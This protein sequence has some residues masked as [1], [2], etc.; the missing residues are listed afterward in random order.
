[1]ADE[2]NKR[3][4]GELLNP[5]SVRTKLI[6]MRLF[7]V[8]HELL[9]DSIIRPPLSFFA[10]DGK[11]GRPVPSNEYKTEVLK[12]DPKGKCDARRGSIEWLKKMSAID[13]S[14]ALSIHEVTRV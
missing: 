11:D 4:V 9:E 10:D 8:A 12:L 1:M 5:E 13:D 2:E 7:M 3:W 6:M 14:D